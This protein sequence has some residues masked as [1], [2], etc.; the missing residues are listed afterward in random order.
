MNLWFLGW[1]DEDDANE[2]GRELI[3]RCETIEE[4]ITLWRQHYADDEYERH[5]G[6]WPPNVTSPD[7][8]ENQAM[9]N[10]KKAEW[11]ENALPDQ[12]WMAHPTNV[13]ALGW[14]KDDGMIPIY[15]SRW[16]A[17]VE[18][19]QALGVKDDVEEG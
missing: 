8:T 15:E 10:R 16:H 6:Y 18:A 5:V 9:A 11:L 3:V 4:A 17:I 14:H 12:M 2:S 1:T 19:K 13:G 7:Q